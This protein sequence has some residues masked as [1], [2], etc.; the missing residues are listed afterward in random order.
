M[1]VAGH[2]LKGAAVAA[3]LVAMIPAASALA[4]GT[5]SP[6]LTIPRTFAPPR[7][8]S[9]AADPLP[10]RQPASPIRQHLHLQQTTQPFTDISTD[11]KYNETD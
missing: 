10:Q 8:G 3:L 1:R 9:E 4:Q 5:T 6:G 7:A 11:R 2:H